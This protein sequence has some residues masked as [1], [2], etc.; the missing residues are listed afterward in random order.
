MGTPNEEAF[1]AEVDSVVS[2]LTKN[3]EGKLVLPEGVEASAQALYA[4]KIE[5]RR[6]DTYSSYS[7]SKNEN[8][9]LKSENA[10]M[11]K[12]WETD[13]MANLSSDDKA[14][15][16]ELRESD[17]DAYIAKK[18]E[19][20]Q[21]AKEQFGARRAKVKE[22][23]EHETELERRT[24]LVEEYNA[25]NPTAMLTQDVIDNDV[26]PRMLKAVEAG[27]ITFDE[28][29]TRATAYLKANKILEPGVTKAEEPNLSR[30]GGGSTPDA[31]AIE[32][33]AQNSYKKEIF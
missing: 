2:Q 19:H 17:V 25:E 28:F 6:R 20:V 31:S 21:A 10:E 11:A 27:E 12:Q 29:V 4:A 16:A 5:I 3:E 22:T 33:E 26:P 1:A 13:A 32:K 8:V 9:A 23:A 18:A 15:L 30:S 24:R 14:D 7:K